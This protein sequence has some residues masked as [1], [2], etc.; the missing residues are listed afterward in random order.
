MDFDFTDDQEQLRDAVRK[1][2][3]KGYDFERRRG[4]AKAGG[5]SREAY[6]QI[7]ELGLCGL[8]IPEDKDGLGMGPVEGMVVMEE[9]GR[10]I[11]AEPFAQTL[12]A[13]A[14]L[15]GYA[16][17]AAQAAWL[18]KIASG[19]ALVVLASQERAA[20][21]QLDVCEAKAVEAHGSWT[22]SATKS[23]VP[24][25]D[26][27]DAFI[28]PA[29]ANGKIALFLVERTA[30]GVT[31]RGYG[32]QDGGR[33]ADVLLKDAPATLITLDGLAALEHAVDIGIA[34]TCAEAV[35]VMD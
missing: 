19:E 16:P 24:A 20:R 23:V 29:Q 18:P 5:F 30:R 32:T 34:A 11:V 25:G 17:E 27:A 2:V 33:A 12:I 21:Y 35:G 9:L 8:Y 15:S 26:H 10:G 7:A 22:L 4:I 3:D 28:V 31:T 13:G 14:V 6:G 1:W